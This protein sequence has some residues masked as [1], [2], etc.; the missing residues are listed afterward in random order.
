[1]LLVAVRGPW[2]KLDIVGNGRLTPPVKDRHR[3]TTPNKPQKIT[4]C[5]IV[6]TIT[7]EEE[8]PMIRSISALCIAGSL[9]FSSI[10][11]AAEQKIVFAGESIKHAKDTKS[12]SCQRMCA[13]KESKPGVDALLTDGWKI[14]TS[15]PKEIIAYDYEVWQASPSSRV[16]SWGCTCIGTQHVL[17]KDDP[18]PVP[19]VEAPN[20]EVELL[21]KET[22]L[23]KQEIALLK[24][25]NEN[26][27]IQLK[28][29]QKKK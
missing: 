19:K 4:E 5:S 21:K 14:V 17:Q 3:Y 15:S 22:E 9:F 1:L 20:K 28:P 23:L 6:G 26:L 29:K 16:L 10:L 2:R 18:A 7:Q 13:G 8:V 27:K 12:D 24:Q 25:E 11:Y